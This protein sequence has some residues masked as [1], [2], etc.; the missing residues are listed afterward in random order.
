ML[1]FP[2][3]V[4]VQRRPNPTAQR[5]AYIRY[6]GVFHD[7]NDV[8]R[9][10]GVDRFDLAALDLPRIAALLA[11][12][13]QSAGVPGGKIGHIE[14]ARGTDGAPVVSVYVAEGSTSG[15]FRVTAKGEPMAI[16]PPS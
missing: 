10:P 4:V 2:T 14:I 12:A 3:H 7:Y 5:D 6:D 9:S 16:Y 11:G 1:L 8:A 15:W 13:P